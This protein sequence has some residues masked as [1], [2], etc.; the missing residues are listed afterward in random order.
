MSNMKKL[1]IV[2]DVS[3]NRMILNSLFCDEYAVLEADNGRTALEIIEEY[4]NEIAIILL[5]IIMPVM[6]GFDVLSEMNRSGIINTVP[7]ILITGETGEDSAL[8]GYSLGVSD[9]I[10][11]PFNP[12]IVIRRVNNVV[13]IYAH[14][15]DLE[16]KLREQKELLD[17]Q[18][19]K[20]RNSNQFVIEALSTTIEFRSMESGE[21]IKRMRVITKKFLEYIGP[22]YELSNEDVE[23]IANASAVHD[24][25]KVA[26]PDSILLKP[27]KL[28]PEEFDIMKTHTLR[29]CEILESL[30]S[31]V[32]LKFYTY[33]YEICRNHHEKWDGRGYPDGIAEDN[34]SV[35]AQAVSLAD[36][37]DALTSKRVYKDA[38][39]HSSAVEMILNGECGQFNPLL[40]DI[41]REHGDDLLEE[42]HLV[43]LQNPNLYRF[44]SIAEGRKADTF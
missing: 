39:S 41:L 8:R 25:G 20:I 23:I 11:K 43:S 1:L 5:D 33:C 21:H 32:D 30:Q 44:T 6:D 29:G 26:I 16:Q 13:T 17:Q 34:I 24:I 35:W 14:Q 22:V 38:I 2:D 36:V 10:N 4:G 40:M 19:E 28:T 3:T 42:L 37:Y 9:L 12:E 15:Q 27:G 7:V 31:Q 18:A